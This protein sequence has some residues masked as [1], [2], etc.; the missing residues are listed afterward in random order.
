MLEPVSDHIPVLEELRA[1]ALVCTDCGLSQTRTNVVFGVG[2]P[3]AR[4]ML[5]GEAP[6][7][8]EDLQGEPFVGAAGKVLDALLE[9]IGLDRSTVYIANVLKCRPPGN[10]DPLPNEIDSCKGYLREQIRLIRPEVVVTLGNFATKLLLSTETG[11]TR[12]RGRVH[13]WWLGSSLVPT[14]HPAAAL[15]G[16]DRVTDQMREDFALARSILDAL[17]QGSPTPVETSLPE[18]AQMELFG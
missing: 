15:R 17:E 9:E 12:L 10:R 14:F 1:R 16:G 4:L 8:N 6:G 18:S 5:V 7:K 11:I 2:D 13:P 3:H